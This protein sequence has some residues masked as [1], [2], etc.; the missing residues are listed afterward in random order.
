M[1]YFLDTKSSSI[2]SFNDDMENMIDAIV[3]SISL[4]KYD[5]WYFG[6]W[7]QRPQT[8]QAKS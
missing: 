5:G 6:F 7:S 2:I 4:K 8:G 1:L 3:Y